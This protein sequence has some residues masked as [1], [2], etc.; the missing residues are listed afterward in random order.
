MM[1]SR[2][3][4]FQIWMI[5]W[6]VDACSLRS[7]VLKI[8]RIVLFPLKMRA[9]SCVPLTMPCTQ[10]LP[11]KP[12]LAS[13]KIAGIDFLRCVCFLVRTWFQ[14]TAGTITHDSADDGTSVPP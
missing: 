11:D 13:R 10:V 7:S 12:A 8:M 9:T 2:L 14:S 6:A 4:V 3:S 5:S 1:S